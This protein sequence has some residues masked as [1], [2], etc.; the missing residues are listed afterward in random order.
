MADDRVVPP[1]SP[2]SHESSSSEISLPASN[3][4]DPQTTNQGSSPEDGNP[5]DTT[6]PDENASI[7]PREEENVSSRKRLTTSS[8]NKPAELHIR[9]SRLMV[10]SMLNHCQVKQLTA[11]LLRYREPRNRDKSLEYQCYFDMHILANKGQH[12]AKKAEA[13]GPQSRFAHWTGWGFAGTRD[14]RRAKE[15]FTSARNTDSKT[16]VHRG[17]RRLRGLTKKEKE[18]N[19]VLL[20]LVNMKIQKQSEEG[21]ERDKIY[22]QRTGRRLSRCNNTDN[23]DFRPWHPDWNLLKHLKEQAVRTYENSDSNKDHDHGTQAPAPS[24]SAQDGTRA[25][26][27]A[28]FFTIEEWESIYR[29]IEDLAHPPKHRHPDS[30]HASDMLSLRTDNTTASGGPNLEDELARAGGSYNSGSYSSGSGISMSP[31]HDE[32]LELD[33]AYPSFGAVSRGNSF[34]RRG[35]PPAPLNLAGQDERRGSPPHHGAQEW[36]GMLGSQTLRSGRHVGDGDDDE[37]YDEER[38]AIPEDQ[39]TARSVDGNDGQGDDDGDREVQTALGPRYP[40]VA[41][42]STGPEIEQRGRDGDGG[43]RSAA[44]T[45][46]FG[47]RSEGAEG[48]EEGTEVKRSVGDLDLEGRRGCE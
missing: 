37:D 31:P 13:P 11:S 23:F 9:L 4:H 21:Q 8:K 30:G 12:E 26:P 46:G 48:A 41:D 45:G 15:S 7:R 1:I 2:F 40:A 10:V 14:W 24:P 32:D 17:P 33:P 19:D 22:A 44:T 35:A 34:N 6:S 5:S 28:R 25:Q 43:A 27:S 39:D 47:E 3:L 16:T 42:G 36:T 20:K 18:E 29:D 38:T